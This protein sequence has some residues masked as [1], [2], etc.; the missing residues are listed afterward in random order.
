MLKK[1]ASGVLGS[2]K[3]STY[4]RG[5]ASGFDSPAA[6]LN[7]LFEH[8]EIMY[9]PCVSAAWGWLRKNTP[10]P[11]GKH[12]DFQ[13]R[14]GRFIWFV[15]FVWFVSLFGPK[16]QPDKPNKP[17]EQERRD[18]RGSSQVL[19]PMRRDFGGGD[20]MSWRIASKSDRIWLSCDSTCCS[21]SANFCANALCVPNISRNSTNALTT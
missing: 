3:S 5:Y 13:E 4:P 15:S 17:D 1:S 14:G 21:S 10:F 16:T 7:S 6:L 11:A 20:S 8:P 12:S 9:K 18:L 2:S 19:N